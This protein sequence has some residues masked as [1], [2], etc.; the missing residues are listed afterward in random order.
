MKD[1]YTVMY[2]DMTPFESLENKMKLQEKYSFDQ[3][4]SLN[5]LAHMKK[6]Q[7]LEPLA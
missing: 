7:S 1:I 4:N 5:Q 3:Y 6:L 2:N